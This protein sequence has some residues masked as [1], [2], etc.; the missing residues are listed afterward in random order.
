MVTSRAPLGVWGDMG[1]EVASRAVS[2]EVDGSDPRLEQ[3]VS[4]SVRNATLTVRV[5][6]RLIVAADG[7]A[8]GAGI[9]LED[10]ENVWTRHAEL[11]AKVTEQLGRSRM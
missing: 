2:V 3:Q 1:L 5:Q 10:V 4:L 6:T 8:V 11:S 7:T 9:A